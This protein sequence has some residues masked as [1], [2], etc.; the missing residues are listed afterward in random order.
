MRSALL[1]TV[2]FA[3]AA[4]PVAAQDRSRSDSLPRELVV[5]LLGGS[6]GGRQVDIRPG[7]ADD[8]LPAALFRD[9][10]LLGFAD[11]RVTTTTVAYFPYAPQATIDTIKAR[12]V[13]AGWTAAPV[14][15]TPERGFVT[16]YGGTMP[17]A[18]CRGRA[19]VVPTV[20]VRTLNRTL[21]I[22]SRQGSDGASFLCDGESR[23]MSRMTS[24]ADTPLPALTPPAGM[25]S[26]GGGGSGMA[27]QE[28]AMTMTTSLS[29]SVPLAS[30]QAHYS[31]LFT[32]AGWRKVEERTANT[33]GVV[34]FE[35]VSGG[36]SWHCALVTSIPS[37]DA[38]DVFLTLR[39]R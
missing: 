18:I 13:A 4:A 36:E 7:L 10:L 14:D 6:L 11:Y 31:D 19:I 3:M 22:I 26:R 29:G 21:A 35:I 28:R 37:I 27:S 16:A 30:I 32:K 5:A 1:T 25:T 34:T 15:T 17:Q 12:L 38:A 33:V 2:M 39:K 9:A 24:R 8:S 23:R 20:A